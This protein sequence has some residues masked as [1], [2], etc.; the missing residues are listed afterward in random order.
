VNTSEK[1]MHTFKHSTMLLM[2]KVTT[3]SHSIKHQGWI[4]QC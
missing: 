2:H 1:L 4:G 3:E